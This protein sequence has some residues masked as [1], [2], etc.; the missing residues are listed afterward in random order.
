M[1]NDWINVNSSLGYR[2]YIQLKDWVGKTEKVFLRLLCKKHVEPIYNCS[3]WCVIGS[4]VSH[5]ELSLPGIVC[6]GNKTSDMILKMKEID[7]EKS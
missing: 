2:Q 1:L 7:C 5:I 4:D 6:R 3:E